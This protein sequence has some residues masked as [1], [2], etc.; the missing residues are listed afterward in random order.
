MKKILHFE[1]DMP[2][3]EDEFTIQTLAMENYLCLERIRAILRRSWKY[4]D[5]ETKELL[6]AAIKESLPP[7]RV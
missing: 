2:N 4:G 3:E 5:Y 6:E 7:E 1:F